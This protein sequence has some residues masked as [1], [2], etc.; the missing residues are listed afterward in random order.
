[1]KKNW[2]IAALLLLCLF[3]LSRCFTS[4]QSIQLSAVGDV[5][6]DRGVKSSIE[7]NSPLYPY[8]KIMDI[9][10][11][12]DIT[13]GNLECPITEIGTPVLKRKSIIFKADPSNARVL[14]AAGFDVFNLANN[15]SMDQ[16]GIGLLNTIKFLNKSG[17]RYF[18]GGDNQSTAEKPLY[19]KLKGISI[20]FVGYSE[21][22]P[23]GYFSIN[24]K[25]D[26]SYIEEKSLSNSIK[27]AKKSCDLLIAIFHWGKEFD[28]YPSKYQQSIAKLACDSGAD[29]IIGHHPHVIQAVEKYKGKYI[30]YSLGNF[31]FDKQLPQ[32]TDESGILQLKITRKQIVN[33]SLLPIKIIGCQPS[34]TTNLEAVNIFN[35]LKYCSEG[36]GADMKYDGRR[37][38]FK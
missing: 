23:E 35:H 36:L 21:F 33:I 29:I 14:K 7:K 37:I 1:M 8:K 26:I 24:G 16:G 4:F 2:Y 5:M 11:K 17:L 30:F 10:N 6:L 3:I 27:R 12:D 13:L 19:I 15:H 38:L 22:P 18:G 31:I 20:G 32:R 9:L 25:P 28:F 34:L